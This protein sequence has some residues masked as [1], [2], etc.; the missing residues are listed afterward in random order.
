[1]NYISKHIILVK[2][3]NSFFILNLKKENQ[4]LNRIVS[5]EDLMNYEKQKTHLLQLYKLGIN[6]VLS[7]QE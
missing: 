5:I 2:H 3:K 4:I 6:K 1:M 7:K